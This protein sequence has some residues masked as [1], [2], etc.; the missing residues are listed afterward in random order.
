MKS[1]LG[2]EDFSEHSVSNVSSSRRSLEATFGFVLAIWL[3]V[4]AASIIYVVVFGANFPFQ[5]DHRWVGAYSGQDAVSPA[6][7]FQSHAGHRIPVV[8]AITILVARLS[9][10]D[11][12]YMFLLT[13]GC[14][15]V[16]ALI[17]ILASRHARG[18]SSIFDIVFPLYGAS[19]LHFWNLLQ[20]LQLFLGLYFL[21]FSLIIA[22]VLLRFWRSRVGIGVVGISVALHPLNGAVGLAVSLPLIPYLVVVAVLVYR[23]GDVAS[24]S[25]AMLLMILAVIAAVVSGSYV[26]SIGSPGGGDHTIT[27]ILPAMF[28]ALRRAWGFLGEGPLSGIPTSSALWISLLLLAGVLCGLFNL[29]RASSSRAVS[30]SLL[31]LLGSV[32]VVALAIALGRSASKHGG[33]AI[34]YSTMMAPMPCLIYLLADR[35]GDWPRRGLGLVLLVLV[36][37]A[38]DATWPRA[39][40]LGR[41]RQWAWI[42]M[43]E[44]LKAGV[45]FDLVSSRYQKAFLPWGGAKG[46]DIART[47]QI[48]QARKQGPF[49]PD[50]SSWFGH[51]EG[52]MFDVL[53]REER[54][55]LAR[56]GANLKIKGKGMG[57]VARLKRDVILSVVD[58]EG[59]F[60]LPP[61]W[62]RIP[63]RH[64]L[65]IELLSPHKTEATLQSPDLP[66]QVAPVR[67]G[68]NRIRFLLPNDVAVSRVRFSPGSIP[69]N[70]RVTAIRLRRVR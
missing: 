34:W 31:V 11:T 45:D 59:V 32:L 62:P 68:A 13:T 49:A 38:L 67:Q 27:E 7:F 30:A 12:R 61:Y 22:G 43:V 60:T 69:G 53:I 2:P 55:L 51:P 56:P 46:L 35:A 28:S 20:G 1:K 25:R 37:L 57:R 47:L 16:G 66:L 21:L 70:Y 36:V 19:V 33:G 10:F 44:D 17:M 50:A 52:G 41:T 8:R 29:R 40:A 5:D 26:T 23:S 58:S 24:R 3:L 18:R 9:N 4:S 64:V 54:D 63:S 42:G 14:L 39:W 6:W 65:E 15:S 48:M